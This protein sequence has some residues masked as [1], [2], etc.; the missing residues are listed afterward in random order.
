MG[1]RKV[2]LAASFDILCYTSERFKGRKKKEIGI[3]REAVKDGSTLFKVWSF[4]KA[5]AG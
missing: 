1:R 2:D 4:G 5:L 3:V